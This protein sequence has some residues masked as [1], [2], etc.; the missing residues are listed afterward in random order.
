MA[1][2]TNSAK[3]HVAEH[4]ALPNIFAKDAPSISSPSINEED[5]K[6]CSNGR[7]M[8]GVGPSLSVSNLFK[9]TQRKS[10]TS[11]QQP[12]RTRKLSLRLQQSAEIPNKKRKILGHDSKSEEESLKDD[13]MQNVDNAEEKEMENELFDLV[14]EWIDPLLGLTMSPPQGITKEML[15]LRMCVEKALNRDELKDGE[16]KMLMDAIDTVRAAAADDD[17]DDNDDNDE[18]IWAWGMPSVVI[19]GCVT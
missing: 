2:T 15:E 3:F 16:E 12:I 6:T 14:K 9:Q 11:S 18:S 8:T 19:E 10:S 17:D 4:I 5:L 13:E 1:H 7:R